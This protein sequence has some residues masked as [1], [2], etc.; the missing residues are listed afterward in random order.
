MSLPLTH[1]DTN[2][3]YVQVKELG[4][5]ECDDEH[6]TLVAIGDGYFFN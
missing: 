5:E 3:S 6:L 4:R 2:I 1:T